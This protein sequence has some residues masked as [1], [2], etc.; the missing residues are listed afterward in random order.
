MTSHAY[1]PGDSVSAA[2]I[3]A[4]CGVVI[5]LITTIGGIATLVLDRNSVDSKGQLTAAVTSA[6][7]TSAPTATSLPNGRPDTGLRF[8]PL[9]NG[10]LTVSGSTLNDVT[11]MYVVIGPKSSGGYDTGCGNVVN[12]RWQTEVTTDVSWP[13][14]PLVT[15]PAYGSC[16][17]AT[18]ASAFKFTFQGTETPTPPPSDEILECAKQ[19]GPSCFDRPG[20]GSPTIYEPNQ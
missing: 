5:A 11:G 8:S 9:I 13:S 4:Y 6:A 17:V 1:R 16:V 15:V 10:K 14:Y 7:I 3:T 2:R 19:N 12:Q 20:F 18:S